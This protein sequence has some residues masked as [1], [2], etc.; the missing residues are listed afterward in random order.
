ML[1][2]K[3]SGK[4]LV[5]LFCKNCNGLAGLGYK[6]DIKNPER[7]NRNETPRIPLLKILK[8][9]VPQGPPRGTLNKFTWLKKTRIIATHLSPSKA[10][11][12]EFLIYYWMKQL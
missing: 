8:M 10:C 1:T 9:I 4:I 12:R 7:I 5:N 3:N 6:Y 11:N 2:V